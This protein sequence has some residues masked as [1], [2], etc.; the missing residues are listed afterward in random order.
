MGDSNHLKGRT[1]IVTG[2]TRGIG[3]AI[4]LRLAQDGANIVFNYLSNSDLAKSLTGDIKKTG[5]SVLSCKVDIR[6]Y[7]QV[8]KMKEAVLEKFGTFDILVNNAG[9][10]R[11]GLLAMISKDDWTDVIDTNLNGTFNA[12]KA[13]IV[14]F[15]KQKKGDIINIASISG[16][17]GMARQT[18]YSASK[19]GIIGFTKALAKEVAGFNVRV[20]A[21]APGFIET[22]MVAS[23]K[24]GNRKKAMDMIPLQRFGKAEEVAGVVNFLLSKQAAYITGQVIRIDGGLGI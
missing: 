11:D 5:V 24:D 6:D 8:Q 17:M 19:A 7:D 13:A 10:I 16:V 23:L 1:A 3:R 2:A 22:D 12:T 4:A 15:M 14:T 9:I 21:V 20:N 18:N